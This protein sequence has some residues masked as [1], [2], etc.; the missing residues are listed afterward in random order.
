M[1]PITSRGMGG[2]GQRP[3]AGSMRAL[4]SGDRR[5]W[6]STKPR[7]PLS[8]ATTQ[9]LVRPMPS[10]L[11]C[12]PLAGEPVSN[13]SIG[14]TIA[15]SRPPRRRGVSHRPGL[16][17]I[18]TT[19]GPL[20]VPSINRCASALGQEVDLVHWILV[21]W[22]DQRLQEPSATH[23]PLD[24]LLATLDHRTGTASVARPC[25]DEADAEGLVRPVRGSP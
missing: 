11:S 20:R 19:A 7:S 18:A 24:G 3:V 15:P 6:Q 9:P 25:A 12:S 14:S 13:A 17:I 5:P 21:R 8:V 23:R 16:L 10:T 2:D 22:F 4:P 1:T